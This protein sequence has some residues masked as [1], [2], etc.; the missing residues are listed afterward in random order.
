VTVLAA[1]ISKPPVPQEAFERF[2]GRWIALRN[3]EIIADAATRE[4]LQ[5]DDRVEST[6][7]LFRVPEPSA[8]FYQARF[9]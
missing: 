5:Q 7:A 9:A 6:D 1:E 3:G 8:H 2:A 4:E